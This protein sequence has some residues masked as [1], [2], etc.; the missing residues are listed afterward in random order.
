[1]GWEAGKV[2]LIFWGANV[3]AHSMQLM[4]LLPVMTWNPVLS[5]A[6]I[7]RWRDHIGTIIKPCDV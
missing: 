3:A 6:E 4:K 7:W 5:E 2:Q 1:M